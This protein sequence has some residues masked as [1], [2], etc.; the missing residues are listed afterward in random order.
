MSNLWPFKYRIKGLST[1][2]EER[3]ELILLKMTSIDYQ[4][5]PKFWIGGYP[6]KF[7][8]DHMFFQVASAM[9]NFE[10]TKKEI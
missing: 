1:S 6:K 8:A 3:E 7:S 10:T 4:G 5:K 2:V 9:D